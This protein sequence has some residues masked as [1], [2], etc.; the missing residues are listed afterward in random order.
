MGGCILVPPQGLQADPLAARLPDAD[1]AI[2]R[3]TKQVS[4]GARRTLAVESQSRNGAIAW[5]HEEAQICASLFKAMLAIS[6]LA[7]CDYQVHAAVLV[8]ADSLT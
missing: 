1:A 3:A 5:A 8:I 2:R 7:G 4:G 6:H